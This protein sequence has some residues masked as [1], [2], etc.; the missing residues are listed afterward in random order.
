MS[1]SRDSRPEPRPGLFDPAAGGE[2][3]DAGMPLPARMRPR[4]LDEFVSQEHLLGPGRVLRAAIEQDR[5]TSLVLWGP[6]GSGKT[7]LAEIIARATKSRFVHLSA[8]TA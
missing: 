5:L 4:A 3:S 2:A 8:V 1:T 7:T 6:P